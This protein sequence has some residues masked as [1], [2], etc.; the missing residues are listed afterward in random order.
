MQR[1]R[2]LIF[3]VSITHRAAPAPILWAAHNHFSIFSLLSFIIVYVDRV[4][5]CFSLVYLF[6]FPVACFFAGPPYHRGTSHPN[7]P[8]AF[9]LRLLFLFH[10][11]SMSVLGVSFPLAILLWCQSINKPSH[12]GNYS[13]SIL[14]PC[15]S[16]G[17]VFL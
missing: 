10:S 13:C 3:L 11:S 15:R 4:M 16:L 9:S 14:P 5:I 12:W 1:H 8:L 6:P 17:L 2:Y 7:Y